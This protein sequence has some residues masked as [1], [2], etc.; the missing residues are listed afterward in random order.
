MYEHN[1]SPST[2]VP[3][4]MGMSRTNG[5]TAK[6]TDSAEQE[7]DRDSRDTLGGSTKHDGHR[8]KYGE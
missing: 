5:T 4:F 8:A 1:P 7:S 6:V 3:L 2:L